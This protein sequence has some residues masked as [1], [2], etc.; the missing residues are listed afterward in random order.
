MEEYL[1]LLYMFFLLPVIQINFNTRIG[2][3]YRSIRFI[4]DIRDYD[5]RL[6]W[7]CR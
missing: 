5:V 6:S 1:F 7:H 4:F 2:D 3:G